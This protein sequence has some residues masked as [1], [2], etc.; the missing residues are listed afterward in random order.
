MKTRKEFFDEFF[1]RLTRSGFR[2][3]SIME[4][5]IAAEVYDESSLFCVITQDGELIF[6]TYISDKVRALEQAAGETRAALDCCT[7]PPFVDTEQ[8]ETIILTCGSYVKVF[9]SIGAVLLCRRTGL[10]GYEFVT[11]SKTMPTH[12]GRRLYRERLFYDPVLAQDSFL[13]RSGLKIPAPLAFSHNEL[14]MLVS[15][16]AKCVMLDNELDSG[17]ESRIRALMAKIEES[18][19]QQSELSPHHY[20]LNEM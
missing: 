3:E 12:N 20:F 6:E 9:E 16:C 8:I 17:N 13:E 7:Q 5:D 2:V 15:C 19:P 4:S 1:S 14:R 18:L 11:C 10:F